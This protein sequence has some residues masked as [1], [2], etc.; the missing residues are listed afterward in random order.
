MQTGDVLATPNPGS[1]LSL[2]E[3]EGTEVTAVPPSLPC[4]RR[5]ML[6][7]AKRRNKKPRCYSTH[8][9]ACAAHS[10]P[11]RCGTAR[12]QRPGLA[13]GLPSIIVSEAEALR[14]DLSVAL[15]TWRGILSSAGA[16]SRSLTL[17]RERAP[18]FPL[19]RSGS[20]VSKSLR[21]G[22]SPLG[23][24]DTVLRAHGLL[25]WSHRIPEPQ[26]GRGWQEGRLELLGGGR[27][28]VGRWVL[29]S[30]PLSTAGASELL[31][32]GWS[33]PASM[34]GLLPA[35]WQLARAQDFALHCLGRQQS[36]FTPSPPVE[37][38]GWLGH[39]APF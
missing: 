33:P 9:K 36:C 32:T 3:R 17:L 21:W 38:H 25:A 30:G 12:R 11:E 27:E 6:Q 10:S 18:S 14:T 8:L 15:G 39:P 29:V 28:G 19:G 7:G 34:L 5:G 22:A 31:G 24:A 2:A 16:G 20:G 1:P 35:G 13:L 23:N 37:L 26:T 4:P